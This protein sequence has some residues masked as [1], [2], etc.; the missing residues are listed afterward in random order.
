M[1]SMRTAVPDPAP[2][3]LTIRP[4]LWPSND[5]AE[6]RRRRLARIRQAEPFLRKAM[7]LVPDSGAARQAAGLLGA[8]G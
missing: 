8:G 1:V 4:R 7:H 2:A 3:S 6:E 5:V